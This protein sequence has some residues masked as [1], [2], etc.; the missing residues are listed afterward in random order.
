MRSLLVVN[1]RLPSGPAV[2][3]LGSS[4]PTDVPSNESIRPSGVMRP[5]RLLPGLENQ[6]L[7]SGPGTIAP[8]KTTTAP[9]GANVATLPA[10]VMRPR[11]PSRLV[12]HTLPSGPAVI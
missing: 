1:H 7:P 12:N 3:A 11:R 10:G 2:M 4:T 9:E 8:G 5:I 6:R